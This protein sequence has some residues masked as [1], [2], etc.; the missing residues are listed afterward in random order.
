MHTKF[1]HALVSQFHW[2]KPIKFME[3]DAGACVCVYAN[4]RHYFSEI[5]MHLHK[6]LCIHTQNVNCDTA[7]EYTAT[8][9]TN[10]LHRLLTLININ[11]RLIY[12]QMD[13]FCCLSFSF[14][15]LVVSLSSSHN[16][17]SFA[18]GYFE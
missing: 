8:V 12:M 6:M 15:Y 1:I 18:I 11:I 5:I 10:A 13:F 9:I 7:N 16:F 14:L 4:C 17:V 2:V 3:L